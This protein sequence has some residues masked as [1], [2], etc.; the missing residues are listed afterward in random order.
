MRIDVSS[1]DTPWI[2]Q[3]LHF[4]LKIIMPE[5]DRNSRARR[6][7]VHLENKARLLSAEPGLS[8]LDCLEVLAKKAFILGDGLPRDCRRPPWIPRQGDERLR[9]LLEY[10]IRDRY[11]TYFFVLLRLVHLFR[12]SD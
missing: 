3:L 11:F 6:R 5:I 1:C 8:F 12:A 2:Q 9:E 10:S 4:L 7:Y